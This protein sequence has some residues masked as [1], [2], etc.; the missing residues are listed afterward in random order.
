MSG[1]CSDQNIER[2]KLFDVSKVEVC[3]HTL[4][5]CASAS[6]NVS[7]NGATSAAGNYTTGFDALEDTI[8]DAPNGIRTYDGWFTTLSDARE[9]DLNRPV[10]LGGTLFFTT[11]TPT[12]GI[13]E[14][15]GTGKLYGMYY[16]TGT[17]YKSSGL[18]AS[19][20]NGVGK[21]DRS[22]TMGD[23]IPSEVSVHV[24][25]QGSSG[26]GQVVN[27][28]GC[29]SRTSVFVQ[30]STGAMGQ[31]CVRGGTA[32]NPFSEMLTWRDL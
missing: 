12:D 32:G 10:I 16:L 6:L 14:A 26:D 31:T 27:G 9:R 23:G 18:G 22:I 29:K 19:T 15:T 4:V 20:L 5:G 25:A 17:A 2:Q 1:Q 24:G 30:K 13:C 11:F 28:T 7:F 8:N 3:D 21:F